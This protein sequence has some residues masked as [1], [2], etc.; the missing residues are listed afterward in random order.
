MLEK[1]SVVED[2]VACQHQDTDHHQENVRV[3]F[4]DSLPSGV[5]KP[6]DFVLLDNS[7]SSDYSNMVA[8][9]YYTYQLLMKD[10]LD[11]IDP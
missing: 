5:C 2:M 4:H 10:H 6:Q 1:P 8:V 7:S 3:P 11:D 9:D